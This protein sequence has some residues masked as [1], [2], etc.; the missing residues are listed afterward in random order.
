MRVVEV[1]RDWKDDSAYLYYVA[2]EG[3]QFIRI[4]LEVANAGPDGSRVRVEDGNFRV[5]GN[6]VFGYNCNGNPFLA[7]PRR[8]RFDSTLESGELVVG[9]FITE[10][11]DEAYGLWLEFAPDLDSR[12][13]AF[14]SLEE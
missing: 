13:T 8:Q 4:K 12:A 6:N 3:C 5:R 1:E 9:N 14:M 10:I 7:G 11:Q 2:D